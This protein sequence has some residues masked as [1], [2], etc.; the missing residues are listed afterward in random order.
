[1]AKAEI[2]TSTGTK[3]TIDGSAD[4]IASILSIYKDKPCKDPDIL[5]VK[6]NQDSG[7]KKRPKSKLTLEDYILDLKSTGFFDT[8]K[9]TAFVK[10]KLDQESHFY[11]MQSVSTRLIRMNEK[12]QLGRIK[13]GDQWAYVKR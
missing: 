9:K 5:L 1:M 2:A 10:E 3:I 13:E 7:S 4:E 6:N 12:R 11:P 8:P